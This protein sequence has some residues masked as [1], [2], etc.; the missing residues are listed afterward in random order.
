MRALACA[1]MVRHA[2][3]S[4]SI[5]RS[6]H[7]LGLRAVLTHALGRQQQLQRHALA[8]Q[9]TVRI[10]Q[11]HATARHLVTLRPGLAIGGRAFAD[12]AKR[13]DEGI[14]IGRRRVL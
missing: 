2:R 8:G 13:G 6:P 12:A 4:P 10:G 11:R 5:T 9:R 14:R 3:I 1:F 7:V